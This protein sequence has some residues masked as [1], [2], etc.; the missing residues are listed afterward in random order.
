MEQAKTCRDCGGRMAQG[1]VGDANYG[2]TMLSIT[3]WFKGVP[4]RSWTGGLKV[5]KDEAKEVVTFRCERC[6]ALQ[7]YAP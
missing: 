2:E 5:N 6:S 1:Y 4:V 3:R 7:S